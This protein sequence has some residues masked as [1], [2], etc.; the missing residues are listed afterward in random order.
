[1]AG[2]ELVSTQIENI[3]AVSP[4]GS[5]LDLNRLAFIL[6]GTEYD[7]EHFHALVVRD[8]RNKGS[9]LI[10]ASGI[11]VAVGF[12]T[13]E[14]LERALGDLVAD[15]RRN[16][17]D[18]SKGPIEIQNTVVSANLSRELDLARIASSFLEAEYKRDQ[19]PGVI[20]RLEDPKATVL[21]FGNGKLICV[22]TRGRALAEKA[23]GVVSRRILKA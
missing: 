11:V 9:L 13:E 3:V 21:L 15:L 20:I 16:G 8:G 12:K 2:V 10:N 19:F 7:P 14:S 22:G 6:P 5:E 17:F 18:V 1:M 4:L 23:I